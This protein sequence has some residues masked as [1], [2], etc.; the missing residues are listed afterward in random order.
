MLEPPLGGLP[1]RNVAQQR[2]EHRPAGL[3][4]HRQR[5]ID[6]DLAAIGMQRENVDRL[7]GKPCLAGTNRASE[8]RVVRGTQPFRYDDR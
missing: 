5:Q 4:P 6:R 8:P 7:A 1:V 3:E 2:A